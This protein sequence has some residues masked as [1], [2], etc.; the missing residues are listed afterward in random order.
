MNRNSVV[1]ILDNLDHRLNNAKNAHGHYVSFSF[2][3]QESTY[4]I[5]KESDAEIV[6][7]RNKCLSATELV[8]TA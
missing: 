3:I 5:K 4:I 6:Y 8:S 1:S 2:L 7:K